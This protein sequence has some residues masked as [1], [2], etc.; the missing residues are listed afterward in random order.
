MEHVLRESGVT[1]PINLL[2]PGGGEAP[3][4][5]PAAPPPP[6]VERSFRFLNIGSGFPRKGIDVLLSAFFTDFSGA[7]DVCLILK[8]FPNIHNTVP[9]QLADSR[10]RPAAPPPACTST[11]I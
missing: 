9:A 11:M 7:A 4:C 10:P 1:V 3:S 2:P 5:A 8:T 6:C